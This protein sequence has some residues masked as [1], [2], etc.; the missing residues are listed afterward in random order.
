MNRLI[1][2]AMTLIIGDQLQAVNVEELR[3][4]PLI[5]QDPFDQPLPPNPMDTTFANQENSFK[6]SQLALIPYENNQEDLSQ[7]GDLPVVPY[8]QNLKNTFV[9]Q[10]KKHFYKDGKLNPEAKDALMSQG[11]QYA[12]DVYTTV[13]D[14]LTGKKRKEAEK[15]MALMAGR[16]GDQSAL[17]LR[18]QDKQEWTAYIDQELESNPELLAEELIPFEEWNPEDV[19][20]LSNYI[21]DQKNKFELEKI[22]YREAYDPD[23]KNKQRTLLNQEN[24]VTFKNKFNELAKEELKKTKEE[25]QEVA[26]KEATSIAKEQGK[27]YYNSAVNYLRGLKK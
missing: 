15:N 26:T 1:V 2:L 6:D 8:A 19:K 10:S 22:A 23:W 27:S 9:E 17:L 25:L 24:I 7:E 18:A 16:L 11:K 4:H 20:E 3:T 12:A 21:A 14:K 5:L 13:H